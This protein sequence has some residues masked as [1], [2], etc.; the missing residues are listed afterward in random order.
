MTTSPDGYAT[1]R[2]EGCSDI[3]ILEPS[4]EPRGVRMRVVELRAES[5][6]STVIGTG[7]T[8]PRLSWITLPA[9]AESG[10]PRPSLDTAFF[11]RL[12]DTY[13]TPKYVGRVECTRCA[14]AA[15]SRCTAGT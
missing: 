1:I 2:A 9:L 11:R 13:E 14:T 10:G 3:T 6:R 5:H 15:K 8:S 4:R 12:S 7:E